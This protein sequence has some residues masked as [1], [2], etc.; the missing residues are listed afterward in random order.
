M[1]SSLH[2]DF[3]ITEKTDRFGQRKPGL[4]DFI[5]PGVDCVTGCPAEVGLF[6]IRFMKKGIPEPATGKGGFYQETVL[7][8]AVGKLAVV[9]GGL[10]HLQIAEIAHPEQT[11][12]EGHVK[13]KL[14][15]VEKIQPHQFRFGKSGID[16]L[17]LSDFGIGQIAALEEAVLELGRCQ[18]GPGKI[19]VF[20][21]AIGKDET[22][23]NP[24]GKIIS[25]EYLA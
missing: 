15:A 19:A 21:F 22:G 8:I 18:V 2:L 11:R 5:G 16:Q 3:K 10:F 23:Q 1:V 14:V 20:K 9:K 4:F 17:G 7:E 25:G 13:G 6:K 12:I 24:I